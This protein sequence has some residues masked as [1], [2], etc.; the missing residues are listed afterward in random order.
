[1]QEQ[2]CEYGPA[3]EKKW[4][5]ELEQLAEEEESKRFRDMVADACAKQGA[6]ESAPYE[7]AHLL[8]IFH[9]ED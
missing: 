3:Q 5:E 8:K 7:I 2:F 9:L 1:M 6:I 4:A